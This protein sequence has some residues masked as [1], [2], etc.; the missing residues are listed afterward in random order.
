MEA[1]M[2]VDSRLGG[3]L[4]GL[5]LSYTPLVRATAHRY[6]GRGAEFDDLVQEGYLALLLLIPRC[7]DREWLP[8]FLK[9]RLPGY[10]RA[11]AKK[12][13]S[14]N[15]AFMKAMTP[16]AALSAVIGI[17]HAKWGEA[18]HAVIVL[19]PGTRAEGEE[20]IEHCRRFIA[21]YKCPKSVELREALPLSGAGKVLKTELRDPFWQGKTR[22]VG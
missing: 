1:Y 22:Q 15:A 9:S 3:D 2:D 19:K 20:I 21:G 17:P 12:T 6:M 14:P 13:R 11:A 18:V 10:V 8:L 4:G 7:G 5:L 16:S